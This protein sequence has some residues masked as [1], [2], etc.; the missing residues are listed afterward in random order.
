MSIQH[1]LAAF[2]ALAGPAFT[3]LAALAADHACTEG[4]VVRMTHVRTA[5]DKFVAE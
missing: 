4:Q 3:S 5:D 2:V 1:R